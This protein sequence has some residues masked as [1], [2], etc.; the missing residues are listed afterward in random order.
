MATPAFERGAKYTRRDV[1]RVLGIPE[2]TSGG[3]WFT[4]YQEHEGAFYLFSN[5]GTPGRTGHDYGDRWEGDRLY[6]YAKTG[7]RLSQPVMAKLLAPD[8]TV[9]LFWRSDNA[10]PFTYAGKALAT[11]VMDTTPVE[12]LWSIPTEERPTAAEGEP[13][14]HWALLANPKR[15]RILD[16]IEALERDLWTVG[17]SDLHKGDGVLI[18]QSLD[19]NG[20]RGIVGLGE[21]VAEPHATTD[22]G[23]PFWADTLDGESEEKRAMV[24]YRRPSGLPLWVGE[25]S[26]DDFLLSLSVARARGGTVFHVSAAEWESLRAI[27]DGGAADAPETPAPDDSERPRGQGRGLSAAERRAVEERAMAL[28]TSYLANQGRDVTDV[29]KKASYDLHCRSAE[30]ELHVEVRGTTGEGEA[31]ILTRAEVAHSRKF[32]TALVVV[33]RIRLERVSEDE[34]VASGGDISFY[35]PWRA[36][37]HTLDPLSYQ[38][39]LDRTRVVTEKP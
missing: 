30:E 11:Q 12:V 22:T 31:V 27:L 29:S 17:K 9:H 8:S 13:P 25:S 21:V 36:D 1:F 20:R 28:A 15:Y 4:G 38:C 24:E 39:T 3:N 33:S 10:E 7:T 23:N 32:P 19:T 14:A 6:W 37:D 26:H 2:N 18:W 5:V 35:M 16:A 34:P